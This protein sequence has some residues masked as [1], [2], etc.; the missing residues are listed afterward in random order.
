MLLITLMLDFLAYRPAQVS[1]FITTEKKI[2]VGG[3]KV[4][5]GCLKVLLN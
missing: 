3:K 1:T 5:G 2:S 4:M